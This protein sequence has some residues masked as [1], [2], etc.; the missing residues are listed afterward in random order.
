MNVAIYG[1]GKFGYYVKRK[2][3]LNDENRFKLFIDNHA[4]TY[5]RE[6]IVDEKTFLERGYVGQ[7]DC[8]WVAVLDN[9]VVENV[10]CSLLHNGYRNIYIVDKNVF[11]AKLDLEGR[12]YSI[13]SIRPEINLVQFPVTEW[14]NLKCKSCSFC[15]NLIDK[16]DVISIEEMEA[17]LKALKEK[18]SNICNIALIGGEPLSV[19]N[20][21]EYMYMTKRYFP[22]T[23]IVIVTN[24]LYI[25]T[26]S[27]RVIQAM[28]DT[29]VY[30]RVSSYKPTLK[31]IDKILSFGIK[32]G[33]EIRMT[34]LMDEFELYLTK[35]NEDYVTAW[36]NCG[37]HDCYHLYEHR[38]FICPIMD[39]RIKH[40]NFLELDIT[41]Q[42]LDE[43]SEYIMNDKNGWE[44]LAKMKYPCK[45][46]RYCAVNHQYVRWEMSAGNIDKSDWYVK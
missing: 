24:G 11:L 46:C 21:D 20:L 2:L 22:N 33:I 44:I 18:F 40:K 14:C 32:Y 39:Y 38:L 27:S 30:L 13:N 23:R 43:N 4:S 17:D 10:V 15:C 36:K 19:M 25:P 8:V 28:I 1:A 42:E 26:L 31:I 41:K 35:E 37:S 6:F 7:V 3:D 9:K 29:G 5:S 16:K 12:V 34:E 45:L